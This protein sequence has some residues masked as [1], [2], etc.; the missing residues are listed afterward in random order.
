MASKYSNEI[1]DEYLNNANAAFD[2]D[3]DDFNID[4]NELEILTSSFQLENNRPTTASLT[5]I[6]EETVKPPAELTEIQNIQDQNKDIVNAHID[7]LAT[8]GVLLVGS[9]LSATIPPTENNQGES[10]LSSF[11]VLFIEGGSQPIM[12]RCKTPIYSSKAVESKRFH[13]KWDDG[14]F[15]FDMIMPET[16]LDP[17]FRPVGEIMISV[18]RSRPNGGN[19]LIGQAA[20]DLTKLAKSGTLEYFSGGIEGR[21]LTGFFPLF[22]PQDPN[23]K[24]VGEVELQL[25]IAWKPSEDSHPEDFEETSKAPILKKSAEVV[26]QS[27]PRPKSATAPHTIPPKSNK[28]IF[29][30]ARKIS[31]KH[32]RKQKEDADRIE[33]EN[34]AMRMRLQKHA[35]TAG[36]GAVYDPEQILPKTSNESEAKSK[37]DASKKKQPTNNLTES[38]ELDQMTKL[39]NLYTNWKKKHSDLEQ[40]IKDSK[41]KLSNLNIHI[42]KY[43]THIDRI[44]QM[45]SSSDHKRPGITS[46]S[47]VRNSIVSNST[48][49]LD[50]NAQPKSSSS[51]NSVSESKSS[52]GLPPS[53]TTAQITDGEYIAVKEEYDVLQKL[54]RGLLERIEIAKKTCGDAKLQENTNVNQKD[55]IKQRILSMQS[56]LTSFW[57]NSSKD[58]K[59]LENSGVMNE[60]SI[61]FD[62]LRHLEVEYD[63]LN[64][65]SNDNN[66]D[67]MQLASARSELESILQKLQKQIQGLKQNKDN[68]LQQRDKLLAL[69][70]QSIK[71]NELEDL[72]GFVTYINSLRENYECH[73]RIETFNRSIQNIDLEMMKLKMSAKEREV[74]GNIYLS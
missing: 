30:P 59:G 66:K 62:R 52:K 25:N 26:G 14:N 44:K 27:K 49:G 41:A 7:M 68:I 34:R 2:E 64:E 24:N 17:I 11:R 40:E 54:R 3:L 31:S 50:T 12:F 71:H 9:I 67:I 37:E 10:L 19:D 47:L 45:P 5:S 36:A 28:Y 48:N 56:E 16:P 46:S 57:I 69:L 38:K 61:I 18:Y 20:F 53:S 23:G 6:R 33:R 35:Q 58:A 51:R 73:E 13:P 22:S 70:R 21:S 65:C 72:R 29:P 55:T 63:E 39:L 60:D 32:G 15:K 42:K 8:R 43:S 4:E 74:I 1:Y